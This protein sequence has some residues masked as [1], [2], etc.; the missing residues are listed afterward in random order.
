MSKNPKPTLLAT[1]TAM[2]AK[3]TTLEGV[4]ELAFPELK[5]QAVRP[6]LNLALAIDASGS[7]SCFMGNATALDHAK[8]A[9]LELIAKLHDTDRIAIVAYDSN[10]KV[11]LQSMP[12]EAA[13][14]IVGQVLAGLHTGGSTALH[15]GWLSAAQLAAP[16]ADNYDISRVLLLSDGQATDGVTNPSALAAEAEKLYGAGLGTSTY[17]LGLNFNEQLMTG[18]AVGGVARYAETAETLVPYF[19]SDFAMLAQTVARSVRVRLW[20]EDNKKKSLPVELL[21]GGKVDADGFWRLSAGVAGA[22]SW[23]AFAVD[24]GSAKGVSLKAEWEIVDLSG[25]TIALKDGAAYERGAGKAAQAIQAR[26]D[27]ARA[28]V[29]AQ[30]A[31]AAARAGDMERTQFHLSN[32]RS[33]GGSS[34]YVNSVSTHLDA[35]AACGDLGRVAKETTYTCAN[36]CSRVVDANEKHDRLSKDRFGLRKSIQGQDAA[37][38]TPATP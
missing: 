35:L 1:R 32:L 18:M 31:A 30:E 8:A 27:E 19:Q 13:R 20:A 14:S 33:L 11:L 34:A 26:V 12:V 38:S 6:R 37:D 2:A 7:M 10:V 29:A 21:G 24:V 5:T 25:K 15:A 17:G 9:A 4:A 3:A 36:M 16:H 23:A 22:S 28:A